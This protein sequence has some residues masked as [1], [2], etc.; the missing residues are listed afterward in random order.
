[1]NNLTKLTSV[2]CSDMGD[3]EMGYVTLILLIWLEMVGIFNVSEKGEKD[4]YNKIFRYINENYVSHS[5]FIF[6]PS[7]VTF[8][9]AATGVSVDHVTSPSTREGPENILV[10][11]SG[12][13][14]SSVG[15]VFHSLISK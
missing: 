11:L 14:Y 4:I 13:L 6:Q 5:L 8:Q 10:E 7:T 9:S 3:W 12:W 1:M 15:F 2:D